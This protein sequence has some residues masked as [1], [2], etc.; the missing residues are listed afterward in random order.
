ML[1][2]D[3]LRGILNRRKRF[4]LKNRIYSDELILTE[5]AFDKITQTLGARFSGFR[6]L[7]MD[8]VFGDRVGVRLKPT[9]IDSEIKKV[10]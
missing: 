3:I 7:G 5:K 4:I 10:I 8:I 9:I 6:L 2:P 1:R